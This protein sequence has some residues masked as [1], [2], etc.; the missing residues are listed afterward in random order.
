MPKKTVDW[1]LKSCKEC[2]KVWQSSTPCV[3][4]YNNK[5]T[6]SYY[7]DFPHYGLEKIK[8]KHQN[9]VLFNMILYS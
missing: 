7:D 2:R 1:S 6:E 8:V 9:I 4:P 5:G 3:D